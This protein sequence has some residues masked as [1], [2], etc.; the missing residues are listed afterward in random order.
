MQIR[1]IYISLQ[2]SLFTNEQ[3]IDRV[4]KQLL[5]DT[6]HALTLATPIDETST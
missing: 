6:T 1:I 5:Y 2:Y 4:K 3:P